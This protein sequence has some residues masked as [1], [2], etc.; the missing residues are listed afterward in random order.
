MADLR[1]LGGSRPLDPPGWG[2]AA[3]Q[4][5]AGSLEGG[6]P[7]NIK[8][9]PKDSYLSNLR[10]VTHLIFLIM[11]PDQKTVTKWHYNRSPGLIVGEFCTIFRARPLQGSLGAKFGR[12]PAKNQN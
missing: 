8:Y 11:G 10:L 7:N 6:S 1:S 4:N 5:P 2:A 3:P 12:K 9:R